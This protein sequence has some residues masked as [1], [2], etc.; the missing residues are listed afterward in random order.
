M[1]LC[2][3]TVIH[4]VLGSGRATSRKAGNLPLIGA[5]LKATN[6]VVVEEEEE[7]GYA[8]RIHED[9]FDQASMTLLRNLLQSLYNDATSIF[10]AF[11]L[12]WHKQDK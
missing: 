1:Y 8:D 5:F 12:R 11:S 9:Q 2:S 10:C 7:R 4:R 3:F 6:I